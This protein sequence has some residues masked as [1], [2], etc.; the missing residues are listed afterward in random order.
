MYHVL[1]CYVFSV[2]VPRYIIIS[3]EFIC[4]NRYIAFSKNNI[5]SSL[6]RGILLTLFAMTLRYSMR[7][8]N[9]YSVEAL[10]W[11]YF[12]VWNI[13]SVISWVETAQ[14][15]F[16]EISVSGEQLLGHTNTRI[17]HLQHGC[18][19]YRTG[20][21]TKLA[22]LIGNSILLMKLADSMII[23]TK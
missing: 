14:S 4:V 19:E 15:W 8:W 2:N 22:W 12:C 20:W 16:V 21:I 9:I 17:C 1:C 6:F 7:T 18:H 10:R 11:L 13:K 23:R 3:M 5:F